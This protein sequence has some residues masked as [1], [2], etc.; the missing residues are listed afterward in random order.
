MKKLFALLAVAGMVFAIGCG[1]ESKPVK[2]EKKAG[3]GTT[4]EADIQPGEKA[5][6]KVDDKGTTVEVKPDTPVEPPKEEPKEEPKADAPKEE[7]KADAP[8]EEP[9]EEPKADAPKE[10]PKAEDK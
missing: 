8:K 1:P 7:P 2:I 4:V 9:K 10:E 6:I 3:G 5:D